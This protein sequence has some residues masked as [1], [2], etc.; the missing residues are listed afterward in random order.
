M[1][2]IAANITTIQTNAA[3]LDTLIG[4]FRTAAAAIKA[5]EDDIR[6][7]QPFASHD[8]RAGRIR[9]WQYALALIDNPSANG[10][11]TIAALAS[12]AWNGVS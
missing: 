5:A 2:T 10:G 12:A 11:Q 1:A 7:Q 9:L 6:A 4:Q 3:T 8:V